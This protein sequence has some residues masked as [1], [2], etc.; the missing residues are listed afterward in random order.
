[1]TVENQTPVK[2]RMFTDLLKHADSSGRVDLTPEAIGKRFGLNGHDLAKN[3]EQLRKEGFVDLTWRDERMHRIRVRRSKLNELAL[4][5]HR[6]PLSVT[7]RVRQWIL[8][9]PQQR[10]GW[11]V[12]TP[13]Q[14]REKLGVQGNAVSVAISDLQRG[15][16]AEVR[17][18]GM[19]IVAV[20][21]LPKDEAPAR[22]AEQNG[23]TPAQIAAVAPREMR[24]AGLS[25]FAKIEVP[26]TPA[27]EQYRVARRMASLAPKDNPYL[28][29]EFSPIPLAEEG[30]LL[31]DRLQSLA[32]GS[33]TEGGADDQNPDRSAGAAAQGD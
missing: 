28:S 17:K 3:L 19:R 15:G 2:E 10:D 29:V 25:M 7:E 8:R 11:V 5:D 31:L 23:A 13:N 20:R 21:M 6:R 22:K 32:G 4:R 14:I 30:L 9:A 16:E 27:L 1:M 24:P 26:P 18:E 33:I 12:V